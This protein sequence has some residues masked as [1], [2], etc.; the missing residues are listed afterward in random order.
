MDLADIQYRARAQREFTVACDHASFTLRRPYPY[1]VALAERRSRETAATPGASLIA[2]EREL[3]RSAV[4]GWED[5]RVSD[6]LE[7]PPEPDEPLAWHAD[8]VELL[9]NAQPQWAA[10]LGSELFDRLATAREAQEA[11]AKN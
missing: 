11:A 6:V 8:A 5:V 10:R 3:L 4:V 9:L 2:L 7:Q 1:E